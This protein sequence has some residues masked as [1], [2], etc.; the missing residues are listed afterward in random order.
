VDLAMDG[1]KHLI[2]IPLVPGLRVAGVQCIGIPLTKLQTP[3]ANRFVGQFDASLGHDLFDVA[4]AQRE[5][6][7]QPDTMTNN[8][9]REAMTLVEGRR[10][11]RFHTPIMPYF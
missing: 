7:V 2:Q 9:R 10:R 1:E 6:I 8:L 11:R 5:A 4:V 3:L